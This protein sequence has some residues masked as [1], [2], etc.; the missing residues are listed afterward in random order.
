MPFVG[1]F[2][3]L[4]QLFPLDGEWLVTAGA[5]DSYDLTLY[6]FVINFEFSQTFIA[7][8]Y[9]LKGLSGLCLVRVATLFCTADFSG[10]CFFVSIY[11]SAY[12]S[13]N[14]NKRIG[15][16]QGEADVF[17]GLFFYS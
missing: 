17:Y 8:N 1:G 10:F 4:F 16:I 6:L 13:Y 3:C 14:F 11:R 2:F 7:L 5:S 12:Y 15:L 9:Q